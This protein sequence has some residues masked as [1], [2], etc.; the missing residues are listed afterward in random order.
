MIFDDHG[1]SSIQRYDLSGST[2]RMLVAGGL[3]SPQ[4]LTLDYDSNRLYW[5][6]NHRES[7]CSI[8]S[9]DTNGANLE[10]IINSIPD[11]K[12]YGI[13]FSVVRN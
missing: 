11:C 2:K 6:E 12:S 8:R 10:T 9:C 7:V 4:A 3:S 1:M 13:D 5:V